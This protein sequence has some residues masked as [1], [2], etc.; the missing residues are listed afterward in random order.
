LSIAVLVCPLRV[1]V[2]ACSLSIAVLVCPLRVT[3]LACSLSIAVL[4]RPL[5]IAIL[6]CPLDITVLAG[7]LDITVLACS[8]SIAVLVRPLGIAILICPLGVT[9]LAYPLGFIALSGRWGTAAGSS[10]CLIF[11]TLDRRLCATQDCGRSGKQQGESGSEEHTAQSVQKTL[12]IR[13]HTIMKH[14]FAHPLTFSLCLL[15]LAD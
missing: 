14:Y 11:T 13:S 1:T 3:V 7:V 8:L 2:L 15:T 4:V 12:E 10:G 9:A 6:I 5:G